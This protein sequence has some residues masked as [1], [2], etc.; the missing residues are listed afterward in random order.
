MREELTQRQELFCQY[1]A[2]SGNGTKAA[3]PAG[4]SDSNSAHVR[5]S[6]WLRKATIQGRIQEIRDES[7]SELRHGISEELRSAVS[8]GLQSGISFPPANRAVKLM[9][10]LGVFEHYQ[11]TKK[12][13]AELE[14][15]FGVPFEQILDAVLQA[16]YEAGMTE[17]E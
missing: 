7:F 4:C 14:E 10:R 16:Q 1:F 12:E 2:L 9:D 8:M 17:A 5:A 13:I 15:R 11:R 3:M 6:E